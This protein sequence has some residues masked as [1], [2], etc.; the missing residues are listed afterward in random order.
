MLNFT[1]A[2]LYT[3]T[4]IDD[5]VNE[6]FVDGL[7]E[8]SEEM[9]EKRSDGGFLITMLG[10]A[11]QTSAIKILRKKLGLLDEDEEDN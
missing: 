2:K 7:K 11:V 9:S 3:A 5:L 6:A 4:E 8:L 1:K 10:I